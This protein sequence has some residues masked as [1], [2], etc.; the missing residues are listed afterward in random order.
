MFVSR[1]IFGNRPFGKGL[2]SGIPGCFC[3]RFLLLSWIRSDFRRDRESGVFGSPSSIG[4]LKGIPSALSFMGGF[5]STQR[6]FANWAGQK[7]SIEG[8]EHV[9]REGTAF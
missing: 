5:I 7:S 2:G 9:G 8:P 6:S 4:T 3:N 1:A